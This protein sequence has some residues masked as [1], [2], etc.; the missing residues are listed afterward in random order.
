[1][2]I[3]FLLCSPTSSLFSPVAFSESGP[4]VKPSRRHEDGQPQHVLSTSTAPLCNLAQRVTPGVAEFRTIKVVGSSSSTNSQLVF[5]YL[6]GI[7]HSHPKRPYGADSLVLVHE[8]GCFVPLVTEEMVQQVRELSS[9][10]A[11]CSG[12][13]FSAEV[14]G[15]VNTLEGLFTQANSRVVHNVLHVRHVP[16]LPLLHK[17]FLQLTPS[18]AYTLV[19]VHSLD[20]KLKKV[21]ESPNRGVGGQSYLDEI[22][23]LLAIVHSTMAESVSMP[24]VVLALDRQKRFRELCFGLSELEDVARGTFLKVLWEEM[25]MALGNLPK[26]ADNLDIRE[27]AIDT[28][29]GNFKRI[30]KGVMSKAAHAKLPLRWTY[31]IIFIKTYGAAHNLPV[32]NYSTFVNFAHA[33]SL[34][35]KEALLA[36]QIYQDL[37]LLYRLSTQSSLQRY[38]FIDLHWFFESFCV[39]GSSRETLLESLLQ[40]WENARQTGKISQA[41]YQ[42]I[43]E[44]TPLSGSLPKN[45]MFNLLQQWHLFHE[46]SKNGRFFPLFLPVTCTSAS[47]VSC[48]RSLASAFYQFQTGSIPPGYLS[49]LATILRRKPGFSPLVSTSSSSSSFQMAPPHHPMSYHVRLSLWKGNLR[50]HLCALGQRSISPRQLS[51][52]CSYLVEVVEAACRQVHATWPH[53]N[54]S[55]KSGPVLCLYLTCPCARF[56]PTT[57]ESRKHLALMVT[58]SNSETVIQ[59]TVTQ[60]EYK[61][62]TLPVAQRIWTRLP[63]EV[64]FK[65]Y[66]WDLERERERRGRGREREGERERRER[67]GREGGREG[68]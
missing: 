39:L 20:N 41:L 22:L 28:A 67:G 8:S 53:L 4:I 40:D 34:S 54:C 50:F 13:S 64:K 12:S 23:D 3:S 18:S 10:D 44:C 59:C 31:L 66:V 42:H 62:R 65:I 52:A 36:L 43:L 33:F 47:R 63:I 60:C 38:V 7:L 24:R 49:L 32:I 16:C 2:Q 37:G 26:M 6:T 25:I 30:K 55:A 48:Q 57:R 51:D 46:S 1:M 45:W 27:A 11:L 19:L 15:F 68:V 56:S 29:Q 17:L 21:L 9:P 5:A 61:L 14:D 35:D 58:K